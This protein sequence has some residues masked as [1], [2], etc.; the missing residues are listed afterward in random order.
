[1]ID[2]LLIES[3]EL[4]QVIFM[5]IGIATFAGD[6]HDYVSGI[7]G[8]YYTRRWGYWIFVPVL[9]FV[10]IAAFLFPYNFVYKNYI[11]N[12]LFDFT[13]K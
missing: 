8:T 7:A 2:G 1:M 11:A 13:D 5:L 12:R 9:F 6:Y 3:C 10:I 4:F